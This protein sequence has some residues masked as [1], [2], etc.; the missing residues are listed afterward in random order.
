MTDEEIIKRHKDLYD[1]LQYCNSVE[2]YNEIWREYAQ[3]DMKV[4]RMNLD[5]N[6]AMQRLEYENKFSLV[7]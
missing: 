7:K 1:Q 4:A 3:L 6:S 5:D 2:K